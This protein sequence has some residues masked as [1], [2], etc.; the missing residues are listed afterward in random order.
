[1]P[2]LVQTAQLFRDPVGC[3]DACRRRHGPVFQLRLVGF[4]RYVLVTDPQ[5]AREIYT[6]DRAIARAGDGRR[7]FLAPV[8]GDNSL[9]C[10]ED[11]QWLRHRKLLGPVFHRSHVD[12]YASEIAQIADREIAR[13]PLEQPFVLH[14]RMQ[15][16][17]LEV[18]LRLV[19]G[20]SDDA[21]LEPLRELLPALT[22]VTG[23]VL[24]WLVPG[25]VWQRAGLRSGGGLARRVPTPLRSFLELRDQVD[26]LIYQEIAERRAQ[27]DD[28]RSDV[29][30][31]LLRA[32]DEQGE[33]MSDVELRDELI[34][35]L[36]AGHETTA[37]GL[38]WAFER[39]VRHRDVLERLLAELD[40][41]SGAD[42]YLDAVV[43][44]TLRTRSV[45]LD[46]P[47][48]LA[49]DLEVGGYVVP[50][51]WYVSP[52][53]TAVQHDPAVNEA[54][55]EFRP[56][57][58]LAEPPRDGW[59]PF[60]GGKRHCVGSHLALLEMKVVIAEVLRHVQLQAV[61]PRPE[62]QAMRHVTLV[63]SKG[64]LVRARAREG[65]RASIP[66]EELLA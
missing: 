57:R 6:A 49:G 28:A 48:L 24:L 38:A 65:R 8:V 41:G 59:V 50:R 43:R 5:L 14:P 11:E 62:R 12:G 34:T 47:R 4:P 27:P 44:E 35:L 40:G 58:F 32:R 63:P 33:A 10:T 1:M 16:I 42:D 21:R 51:G 60:G 17:T 7:D 26:V 15:H 25:Q 18:I 20:I 54:P 39:L 61:D 37:T 66:A 2:A 30:S 45:V 22:D 3:I 64:T 36:L 9:L 52:A 29:L 55:D 46:T 19:F 31:M 56:E 53:I 13:W 23:G